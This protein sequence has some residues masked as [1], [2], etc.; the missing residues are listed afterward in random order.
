MIDRFPLWR[1][2]HR[3]SCQ[4]IHNAER[5]TCWNCFPMERLIVRRVQRHFKNAC[6]GC[7]RIGHMFVKG[8]F[9]FQ[10]I[11]FALNLLIG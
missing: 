4:T 11:I 2:W 9:S 7:D 6:T 8:L 3:F 10:S 5:E 1:N